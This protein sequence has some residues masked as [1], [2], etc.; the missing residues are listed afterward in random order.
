MAMVLKGYWFLL[1]LEKICFEGRPQ[2]SAK[3]ATVGRKA[4][5]RVEGEAL[6]VKVAVLCEYDLDLKS[7]LKECS[8]WF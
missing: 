7:Y 6:S 3:A 4:K 5:S 2:R 1:P 8:G